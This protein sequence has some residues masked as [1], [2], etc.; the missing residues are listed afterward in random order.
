MAGP[1]LPGA[2]FHQVV[3][4]GR[5]WSGLV[6]SGETLR[7][8]DLA[9]EQ[10]VDFL[11]Y[12]AADKA[13]RYDAQ[14]TLLTR[15][16]TVIT[17]DSQLLSNRGCVLMTVTSD[18]LGA[19]DTLVGCCSAEANA[20]RFGEQA[21]QLHSCRDNFLIE[22]AKHGMSK[23]DIVPNLNFFMPVPIEEDGRLAIAAGVQKPGHYIDLLTR[24]DVLCVLSNCPQINNPC[25]GFDPTP[26][27]VSISRP[28]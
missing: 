4:P 11:V 12:S 7:I 19:H 24:M 9:G 28:D 25:N 13:E 5:S 20:V 8:T 3:P 14:L 10:A 16:G 27:Q 26:I 2:R 22:L 17:R 21:A 23:R 6:R 18:T 1:E 15:G